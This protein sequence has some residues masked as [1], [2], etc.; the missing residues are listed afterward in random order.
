MN[1][2]IGFGLIEGIAVFMF[3]VS[4]YALI[5]SKSMIRSVVSIVLMELS[6]VVFFLSFVF[7]EGL[8]PPM[9]YNLENVVDPVPQALVI[10]AV[11]IG[12]AISAVNLEMLISLCR[13]TRTVDWEA[14]KKASS[15]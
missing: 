3:F 12:V 5:T 14:A 6:I 11:I 4:F 8:R 10:T 7:V 13:K 9:G 15:E 2:D 1:I